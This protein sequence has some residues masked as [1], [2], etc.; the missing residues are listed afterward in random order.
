MDI[1]ILASYFLY[2]SIFVEQ[3]LDS[4]HFGQTEQLE[5][6][7]I[8]T[9]SYLVTNAFM[10]NNQDVMLTQTFI[11]NNFPKPMLTVS[12]DTLEDLIALDNTIY[13]HIPNELSYFKKL[14]VYY[15]EQSKKFFPNTYEANNSDDFFSLTMFAVEAMLLLD[16]CEYNID[17][18]L[19]L[20]K[21]HEYESQIA[22]VLNIFK[23]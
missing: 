11:K 2:N 5:I 1:Q 14:G 10:C 22:T 8:A 12:L 13:E 7:N 9:V 20:I 3:K 15:Y 21:E 19:D 17:E 23:G 16:Q 18:C 4:D 6:L